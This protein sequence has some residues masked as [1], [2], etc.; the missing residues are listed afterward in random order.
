MTAQSP[1][2]VKEM[3]EKIKPKFKVGGA[4]NGCIYIPKIHLGHR[5]DV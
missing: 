4:C 5:N 2:G 3:E 1:A